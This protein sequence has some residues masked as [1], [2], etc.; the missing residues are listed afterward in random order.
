MALQKQ[1][2]NINFA[3]GLDLK[4]DAWQVSPG[5]FL[6]LSNSIFTK[7]G[8]LQKRN[9]FKKLPPV[10]NN[11]SFISTFSGNLIAT[12]T[13]LQVLNEDV[14]EWNNRGIIQ[15]LD[16]K[17][18]VAARTSIN[19][20]ECDANVSS[21]GLSCIVYTDS[22]GSCYYQII[23]S[24]TG[25]VFISQT[26]ISGGKSPRAFSLGTFFIITYLE[27]VSSS[28]HLR[29]ISIPFSNLSSPSA[30]VDI[31]TSVESDTTGY[32]A[33]SAGGQLY[34]AW[35]GSDVGGA[36]RATYIDSQL[37]QHGVTVTTG[38]KSDLMSVTVDTSLSSP[39]IWAS[40]W[41]SASNNGFTSSYTVSSQLTQS[42]A[43]TQII[44]SIIISALTST[45]INNENTIFY[46][47]VHDYPS[48]LSSVRSDFVSKIGCSSAG[49]VGSAS[50]VL[51]GVGLVGKSFYLSSTNTI[52]LL[53]SYNGSFQPT[54]FLID[55]NGNVISKLSYENSTGYASGQVLANANVSTN[56][57]TYGYLFKFQAV[58][59]NK[60]QGI[61]TPSGIY[62][63]AGVNLAAFSINMSGSISQEI[64]G[65]LQITGGFLWIYDGAKP[66][67]FDFHIFPED[68]GV[69]TATGSGG[70]IAQLYYYYVVYAWTDAQGQIH[71]SAPSIPYGITTTTSNS[72]NTL[73]IPTYRQTYK[74]APNSVRIEIYRWSTAQQI[75][76]LITS[77]IV[78][79]LNDTT[80]DTVTYIDADSDG[81]II[82]NEIIY[83]NGGIVE[84]I[85]PPATSGSTLYRSRLFVIDSEDRNL[86]W[87]SKVVIEG[88]PVEF[89]D[90]LTYYIAP[91]FSAQGSTGPV[92]ALAAMD[93]KLIIFKKDAI[94]YITGD[95]PDNLGNNSDYGD[96]IFI[97]GTVG[98]DNP[99]SIVLMPDGLMFQSDKGIWLLG[100]DLST[101][102]IGAPVEQYNANTV[103]SAIVVPGTNQVRF[104]LSEG[105]TL[106]FDYYYSQWGTFSGIP[107]IA[108]TIYQ[109]L[110]TFLNTLGQIYQENPGSYLDGSNP[111][112]L[113][114]TSSWLNMSGLQGYQR[115]YWFFLIGQYLSPHK[116][117]VQ[118]GY[119]YNPY[120]SQQVIIQ[121]DNF[122]AV[123]GADSPYGSGSPYG[124]PSPLEQWRIFF[125][126]QT[127]QAFQ[128]SITE[129]YDPSFGVTAGAGLTLSGLDVIFGTKNKYPRLPASRQAG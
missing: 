41:D 111:V 61:S 54:N 71:R 102:Y 99:Q 126:Q 82:G 32:D 100:R 20:N 1:N 124:G 24:Q 19:M 26:Q 94:Y 103:L 8:L 91:T 92:T 11:P 22:S 42:L 17:T 10:G 125:N 58:P 40:F 93:D 106:M 110:H 28:P 127:C 37:N 9:G 63:Q 44:S 6:A 68:V 12:G 38:F 90:L 70:L 114:F 78:P 59:V 2:I 65:C 108:S 128:I 66:V 120:P 98:C 95:G 55:Q 7:G 122:A 23:D 96:P 35:N 46:E 87:F 51:R 60:A 5:K 21:N 64:A 123:Y 15:P 79:I 75:P 119:N 47:T 121:P 101:K 16:L 117:Q 39:V 84:D 109:G 4:T 112:L 34:V 57:V 13:S 29:Y 67:E 81:N 49:T 86:L 115:A 88:T 27:T 48:P 69:S 33:A 104:T 18:V 56:V 80:I 31:S 105:I 118:I 129:I 116:L 50:V 113:S 52:Y 14:N 83:T 107:A 62:G 76:F 73:T 3:Q 53:V 36:I 85:S 43:P 45:A 74:T 25:Q 30:P 89:S 72:T 77:Q 97:A